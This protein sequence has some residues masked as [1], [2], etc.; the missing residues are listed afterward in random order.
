[1]SIET[2]RMTRAAIHSDA[3][4]IEVRMSAAGN[5]QVAVRSAE[6]REWHLACSGDLQAGALSITP[7]R[8]LRPTRF[9][10]LLVDVESRR[11]FVGGEEVRLPGLEFDLL[12]KLAS[13]PSRVFTKQELF[14]SI[15]G[16]EGLRTRTLDS[17][18]SRVRCGLRDA[19]APGFV[20]CIRGVGYKLWSK[21]A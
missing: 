6:Q 12:A 19:G 13:A 5:W 15:W 3:G 10:K 8:K 21:A 16:Y 7:E 18:A 11:A 20:I 4:E 1:M 17:H 14:K 9:G 2:G